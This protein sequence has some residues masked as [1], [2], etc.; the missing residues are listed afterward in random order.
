MGKR[1]I[2]SEGQYGRIFLNEQKLPKANAGEIQQ[3]LKGKGI[4]KN[5]V[6]Y[7]FQDGTAKAF[8]QYYYSIN[9][10]INTVHKLWKKLKSEKRDVG[11]TT[12]FGPKMAKVISD[13]IKYKENPTSV[14]SDINFSGLWDNIKD[15][16]KKGL[17]Y[18]KSG[19]DWVS[20]KVA[21]AL[22]KEHI[23]NKQDGNKFREWIHQNKKMVGYVNSELKKLGFDEKFSK[24][25]PHNN[26]YFLVAWGL[27]GTSYIASTVRKYMTDSSWYDKLADGYVEKAEENLKEKISKYKSSYKN[28]Y[29]Y[30][31]YKSAISNWESVHNDF[32]W[33]N[34]KSLALDSGNISE[35]GGTLNSTCIDPSWIL[36]KKFI[37]EEKLRLSL[38]DIGKLSDLNT[39]YNTKINLLYGQED[40]LKTL[41]T[42]YGIGD[43]TDWDALDKYVELSYSKYGN[44]FIK[45]KNPDYPTPKGDFPGSYSTIK[46]PSSS[47]L[48]DYRRQS[49]M[50]DNELQKHKYWKLVGPLLGGDQ[51]ELILVRNNYNILLDF[52]DTHNK[53]I[54]G[55]SKK[56]LS[57]TEWITISKKNEKKIN[58]KI[59][60]GE[61]VFNFGSPLLPVVLPTDDNGNSSGTMLWW[62]MSEACSY[63]YGGSF[64]YFDKDDPD[65]PNKYLCCVK[66]TK[67][68]QQSTKL[69]NSFKSDRKPVEVGTISFSQSCKV[70]DG[71]TWS[72]WWEDK[73]EECW[74][75]WHCISDILSIVVSFFGPVGVIIGAAIDIISAAGYA[76]EQDDGWKL[77]MGLTLLGVIPGG[78][79][80]ANER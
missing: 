26:D 6:D 51:K 76:M 57:Q 75:D 17:E 1:V 63:N 15:Y 46:T 35:L 54:I 65:T 73:G 68:K 19:V 61:Q 49:Q 9:T 10:D 42:D 12:G 74:T 39:P 52:V 8:A 55:Q 70:R 7:K 23:K 18:I 41:D 4:Y 67:G 14:I 59:M 79:E 38:G 21:D 11:G 30:K 33:G 45:P 44:N 71:R 16:A 58:K 69:Y 24:N 32:K 36:L 25:G 72:E 34:E 66:D 20:D 53:L 43:I 22:Y 5:K 80:A 31:N 37:A 27:Y 56:F 50:V 2:I 64:L 40:A 3:F 48:S 28:S 77:N 78:F 29:S 60:M 13:M 47:A 62:S